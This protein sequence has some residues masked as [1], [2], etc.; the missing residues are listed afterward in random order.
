[1]LA[2]LTLYE[3]RVTMAVIAAARV[4]A[5]AIGANAFLLALVSVLALVGIEVP[6]L[7]LGTLARKRTRGVQA[8][9]ALAE[10]GNRLALVDI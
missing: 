5:S 10:S 8:L 3:S 2:V 1:M 7:S 9:P 6:R 4:Y